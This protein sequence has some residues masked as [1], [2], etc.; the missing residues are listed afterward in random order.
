MTQPDELL[1]S[2]FP[3]LVRLCM[4]LG[5][6]VGY[7]SEVDREG[8]EEEQQAMGKERRASST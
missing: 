3:G 5:Q 7:R 8:R 1:S 4:S 6:S 2:G